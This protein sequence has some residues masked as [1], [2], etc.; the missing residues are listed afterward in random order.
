[1]TM[2]REGNKTRKEKVQY[3][4]WVLLVNYCAILLYLVPYFSGF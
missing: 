3:P 4:H 1:M 2:Y